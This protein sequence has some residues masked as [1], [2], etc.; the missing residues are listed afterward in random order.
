VEDILFGHER[1]SFTGAAG[2]HRG[3]FERAAGGTLFLDEIGELP[4]AQQATLLRVL[5][6]GRVCRIGGEREARVEFRLVAA[7]NRDLGA[8]VERGTFR[9][10]LYHRL[11]ALRI[12]TPPLRDRPEDVEPLARLFLSDISDDVGPRRITT[13][14]LERL[15][16]HCWPGNARELRNALYRAA[17]GC[18][19]GIITA[20]D[21]ELEPPRR[22]PRPVAF[23]LGQLSDGRVAELL[24]RHRGNVAAAA[25]ELGVARSTLRD[26][27]KR[28]RRGADA[29]PPPG[30]VA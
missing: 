4:T 26:R 23:R 19:H 20:G 5:D 22:S 6:D 9:E 12:E 3:V 10:D 2:S 11:A 18:A 21:L 30:E 14:A 24:D 13:G 29:A 28:A 1:G 15:A 7:T 17:V 16:D 25:R 8:A 27:L